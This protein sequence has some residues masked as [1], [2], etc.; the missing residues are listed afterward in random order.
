ME[1]DQVVEQ[2][3]DLERMLVQMR[4]EALKRGKDWQRVKVVEKGDER[5]T[6]DLT[7]QISLPTAEDAYNK[8]DD[9][10]P[11]TKSKQTSENA[12]KTRE[13]SS[14]KVKGKRPVHHG[15]TNSGTT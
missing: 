14:Q 5:Q 1:E 9:R 4:A 10:S 11:S 15:A 12:G 8:G 13:E 3:D 7:D 2:Q 6:P